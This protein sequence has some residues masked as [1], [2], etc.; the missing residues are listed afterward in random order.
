MLYFVGYYSCA[1]GPTI[2][3]DRLQV[4]RTAESLIG[5]PYRYGGKNKNGFDCSGFTAYVYNKAA[6]RSIGRS[7]KEQAKTGK[8]LKTSQ[9]KPG[10]LV[11]FKKGRKVDHVGIVY[12][13]KRGELWM[14]HASSSRGVVAEE[15]YGSPYWSK[16]ML[17][18]RSYL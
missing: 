12:K 14:I 18:V 13:S 6:D 4:V 9:Y 11:F 2:D 8:K 10:D 15:I 16:K 7:S 5:S 17:Y 3:N 1:K